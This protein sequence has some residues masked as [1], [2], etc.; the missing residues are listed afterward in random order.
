MMARPNYRNPFVVRKEIDDLERCYLQ[1]DAKRSYPDLAA[2]AAGAAIRNR[3]EVRENLKQIFRWKLETFLKRRIRFVI[4][5]PQHI[6]DCQIE[7]TIDTALLAIDQP[8]SVGEALRAFDDLPGVGIPVASAFL[9]ALDPSRFTV[10]DRQAYKALDV[11]FANNLKT[12]EYIFYLEFCKGQAALFG[13]SLRSYDRA[14]WQYGSE[15]GRSR[16][17]QKLCYGDSCGRP[18]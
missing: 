12:N 1:K 8:N 13:V 2:L 4:E 15:L 3:V 7:K 9:T 16:K 14:L 10:I 17:K 11:E 5:F 18:V 6:S